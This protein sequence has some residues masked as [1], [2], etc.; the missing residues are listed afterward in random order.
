MN[1][2]LDNYE[3]VEDLK[4]IQNR[5]CE[6]MQIL[7][8]I[9]E[10][11]G[12]VYNLFGGSLL[13]AVRHQGIIPWDDDIDITMP[14]PDYEKLISIIKNNPSDKYCIYTND[15]ENYV[16][17][18]AKFCSKD[19]ILIERIFKKELSQIALY[20]DIFPL[21]GLPQMSEKEVQKLYARAK[22]YRFLHNASIVKVE[23]SPVWWKKP[24]VIYRWLRRS[25]LGICGY[26]YYLKKQIKITRTYSFEECDNVAFISQWVYGPKAIISKK[27]YYNRKLYKFDKYEFWGVQ[28][29]DTVLK[30]LYGDYMTPPPVEVRNFRHNYDLYIKK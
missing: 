7:H 20:I 14:R 11:N 13:G 10:E 28:D 1:S 30:K 12:L 9:C 15:D 18:F 19:T 3:K 23:A 2:K 26:K 4:I 16:Y 29:Y 21:D 8:N 22:R 5:L 25:I 24:Y 17:P 27:D 6:L